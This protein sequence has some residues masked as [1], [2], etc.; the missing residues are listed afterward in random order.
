MNFEEAWPMINAVPG[1]LCDG[2]EKWLFEHAL[3]VADGGAVV[4]IGSNVGRSSVCIA[5]AFT[6][7]KKHLY[8]FDTFSRYDGQLAAWIRNID[9][10]GLNG[11]VT[12]IKGDSYHELLHMREFLLTL[13]VQMA[14]IDGDHEFDSVVK[15]YFMVDAVMQP[16]GLI[17]LHD[18]CPEWD[19][20]T[21]V[22]DMVSRSLL[23]HEE[24]ATIRAGRK[25]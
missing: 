5:S 24:C 8:C 17:V 10:C 20:P 19:G 6:G 12:P 7:T 3:E 16:R 18:V 9:R 25:R 2:Q 15:D 23:K 21:R 14:F 11:Y 1:E 22:W 4:E 13:D